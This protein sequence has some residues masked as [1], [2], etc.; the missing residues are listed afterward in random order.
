MD[1]I[2]ST[3]IN[4]FNITGGVDGINTPVTTYCNQP[5]IFMLDGP[6]TSLM[7]QLIIYSNAREIERI[8]AYD[9]VGMLI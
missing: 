8:Q 9:Q 7:D 2:T 6:S 1:Y 3:N 5:P 4:N